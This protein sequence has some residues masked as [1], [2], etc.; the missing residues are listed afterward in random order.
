M[1]PIDIVVIV[2]CSAILIAMTVAKIKKP[3]KTSNGNIACS[4]EYGCPAQAKFKRALKNAKK[5]IETNS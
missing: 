1:N 5:S 4:G 2:A 3:K